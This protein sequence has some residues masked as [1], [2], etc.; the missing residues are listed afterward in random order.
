MPLL[1]TVPMLSIGKDPCT[2]YSDMGEC[3]LLG[4][5]GEIESPALLVVILYKKKK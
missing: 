3:A 4:R 2:G 1:A 5:N